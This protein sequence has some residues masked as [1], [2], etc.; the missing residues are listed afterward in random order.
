MMPHFMLFKWKKGKE[1]SHFP[2]VN[3]H[4]LEAKE[5]ER[6]EKDCRLMHFQGKVRKM[7]TFSLTYV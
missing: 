5:G 1:E 3:G 2:K 7:E 4:L 6:V